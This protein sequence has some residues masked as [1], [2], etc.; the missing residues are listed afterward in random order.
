MAE[1]YHYHFVSSPFMRR[2]ALKNTISYN[3]SINE[4]DL[5][6]FTEPKECGFSGTIPYNA[7]QKVTFKIVPSF[8]Y[9]LIALLTVLVGLLLKGESV[10]LFGVTL[11]NKILFVLACLLPLRGINFAVVI[12]PIDSES[13]PAL[14]M[15]WRWSKVRKFY[16]CLQAALKYGANPAEKTDESCCSAET[17]AVQN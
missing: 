15:D 9:I 14:L 8:Q 5:S 1:K 6:L 4:K 7:I 17:G 11:T 3:L 2:G 16:N 13:R 12:F 10:T